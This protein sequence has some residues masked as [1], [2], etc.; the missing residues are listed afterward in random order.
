MNHQIFEEERN[1]RGKH[2]QTK[3]RIK[4]I[5]VDVVIVGTGCGGSVA[6]AVLS[7]AGHQVLVL[8]KGQYLRS[9]AI[10]GTE[11]QGFDQMYERG[12][13]VVTE[14]SGVAVLAGSTFGG[15]SAV[16]WACCLRTPSYVREEWS[17]RYGLARFGPSSREF[18]HALDAVTRRLGVK[19][20]AAVAHNAPHRCRGLRLRNA[21][22]R[23]R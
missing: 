9:E 18:S 13:T 8:E 6:A 3:K 16:N 11:E 17:S 10:T 22:P 1:K 4:E 5:E 19:E 15:G 14:D 21:C 20:G 7:Q 12:A 2:T 23:L